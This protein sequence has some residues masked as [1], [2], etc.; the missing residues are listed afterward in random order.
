M[1]AL[2]KVLD[3]PTAVHIMV[4]QL[5]GASS[6]V[7]AAIAKGA[8]ALTIA[9]ASTFAN[10]DNIRL[11]SGETQELATIASGGG[12]T[13]LV[14]GKG[15]EFAHAVG[16]AVV[17]QNSIT[18]GKTEAAGF[19]FSV[20]GESVDVFTM[21]ARAAYT[22]LSGYGDI[23]WNYPTPNVTVDNFAL[24]FG[25]LRS[26]LKGDGTN[27]Q[28][29][30]TVG[31]RLLTS[32]GSEFGGQSGLNLVLPFQR[33]DG[34]FGALR[35]YNL[36]MDPTSFSASFARG[37]LTTLPVSGMASMW[38]IDD[39]NSLW[40]PQTTLATFAG[41]SGDVFDS[42][43]SV[44][45][46]TAGAATTT[47]GIVAAGAYVIPVTSATGIVAGSYV[48]LGV[49]DAAEIHEV[50]AVATLNLNL[51]TSVR[52]GHAS[53]VALVAQTLVPNL[54][55]T[56]GFRVNV[57]GSSQVLRSETSKYSFGKKILQAPLE[58]A[59][60]TNNI[61]TANVMLALG[62]PSGSLVSSILSGQGLATAASQTLVF[63]GFT[64][65]GETVTIV[66]WQGAPTISLTTVFTQAA[67][68]KIQL[69][70]KPRTFQIY[71]RA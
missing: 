31:P 40:A 58:L 53:G 48:Q 2:D 62:L 12:T 29:T 13:S 24:A 59:W 69:S 43:S 17:E 19:T 35:L 6:T 67:E 5:S 63:K 26:L 20:A 39:T 71:Q 45:T 57:G 41:D 23:N 36:T 68:A 54:G 52:A 60:E 42:I 10:G 61:T 21:D 49:G 15:A 47:T 8:T 66:G 44:N 1:G 70:F 46:V 25:V 64:K 4:D 30:G 32:D 50:Q 22:V 11:G 7:N 37:A 51:Y 9:A 28:Q 18:L 33:V 65:S 16:E 56:G 55:V 34:T 38:A 3:K 14:L 27:A